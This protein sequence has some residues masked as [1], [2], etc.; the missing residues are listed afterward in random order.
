MSGCAAAA[1][2]MVC[3]LATILLVAFTMLPGAWP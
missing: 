1:L 2:A 3:L